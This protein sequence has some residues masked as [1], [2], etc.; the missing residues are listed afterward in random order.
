MTHPASDLTV[1]Q[2]NQSVKSLLQSGFP[3]TFWIRGIV[4]GLRRVSGRGHSY[5]QLADP[6]VSGEQPQAVADC[7]LFAGDRS[8]IALEVGRRAGLFQLEN[9]T[10]V[11]IRAAVSFWERSGR[12][13]L[14]MK[15]FDA[16]FSSDSAAIHLNRLIKQLSAEGVL[17]ENDSLPF[18]DIPL[19]IG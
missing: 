6:S 1:L 17:Q 16:D 4:T 2:L 9:N 13:Q 18:P 19:N 11:R 3:G 15:G 10:E 8:R 12:F 14:V 7:A 5:F